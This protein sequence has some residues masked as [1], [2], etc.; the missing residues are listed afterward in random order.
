[1]GTGINIGVNN[2]SKKVKD[3]YIGISD[4]P[5]KIEKAWVGVNGVPKLF[6]SASRLPD[7]YQEVEYIYKNNSIGLNSSIDTGIIPDNTVNIIIKARFTRNYTSNIYPTKLCLF[8]TDAN[9]SEDISINNQRSFGI[10]ISNNS[11]DG[12]PNYRYQKGSAQNGG[13]YLIYWPNKDFDDNDHIINFNYK[14][15]N[16][17]YTQF[18]INDKIITLQNDKYER[19]TGTTHIFLLPNSP[20]IQNIYQRLYYCII[21]K[22]EKLLRNFIPCYK[23]SN[24][25]VGLYDLENNVFYTDENGGNFGKGSSII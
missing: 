24:N 5:K 23:I 14:D 18:K 11:T 2:T 7:G 19:Y 8:G 20:I 21:Y 1:M 6:Y 17:N 10:Y 4:K 25:Q 15:E 9:T 3:F 12:I 16:N 13:G 22:Q